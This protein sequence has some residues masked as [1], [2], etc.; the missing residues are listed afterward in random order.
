MND[1]E[2]GARF[3]KIYTRPKVERFGIVTPVCFL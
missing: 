1:A 2:L 3:G